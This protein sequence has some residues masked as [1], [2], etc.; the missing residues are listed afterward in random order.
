MIA[1]PSLALDLPLKLLV[2]EDT[3]GAVWISF[4]STDYLRERHH[5]S[6]EQVQNIAVV[7]ILAE[8]ATA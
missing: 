3:Q 1:S 8:R 2:W 6:Q 5:L 7:P 4:N